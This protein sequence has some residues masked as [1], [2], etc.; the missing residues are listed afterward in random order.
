ML[1]VFFLCSSVIST[2]SHVMCSSSLWSRLSKSWD[3][4]FPI[5]I[6]YRGQT[7]TVQCRGG[8]NLSVKEEWYLS[9]WVYLGDSGVEFGGIHSSIFCGNAPVISVV[10]V[11]GG[12][13]LAGGGLLPFLILVGAGKDS[14]QWGVGI[15]LLM[16][17]K[18]YRWVCQY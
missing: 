9:G 15:T 14:Q 7:K 3:V 16:I 10:G 12:P 6:F 2:A 5:V 1:N 13:S 11:E 8:D 18:W 4:K 17:I